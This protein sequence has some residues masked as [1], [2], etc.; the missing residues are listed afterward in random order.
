MNVEEPDPQSIK[1]GGNASKQ[2][3]VHVT[4]KG[5]NQQKFVS[6]PKPE[7]SKVPPV[8]K[9]T[10]VLESPPKKDSSEDLDTNDSSAVPVAS[11]TIAGLNETESEQKPEHHLSSALHTRA[12]VVPT[13]P[14]VEELRLA[15]SV[16]SLGSLPSSCFELSSSN[17][18]LHK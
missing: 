10:A 12:V 9:D 4:E 16:T 13:L 7:V 11:E 8:S 6:P 17:L 2:G 18:D 14:I 5:G 3:P 1:A 15:P